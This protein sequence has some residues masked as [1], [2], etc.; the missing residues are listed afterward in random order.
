LHA[1]GQRFE[2]AHL[3]HRL[4]VRI[5]KTGKR[6]NGRKRFWENEQVN[7]PPG[8]DNYEKLFFENCIVEFNNDFTR[9]KLERAHG[10]CL[11][12]RGRRRTW[13]TAIS[14]G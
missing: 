12:V 8:S 5:W 3:H 6:R 9:D 10:G 2:P 1:G 13:L 4:E 7:W 11:G 14:L